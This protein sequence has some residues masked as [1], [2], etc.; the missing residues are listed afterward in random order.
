MSMKD[1]YLSKFMNNVLVT[2]IQLV[3]MAVAIFAMAYV[4]VL[5]A[6]MFGV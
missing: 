2:S 6:Y 3:L 1:K 5:V 4:L